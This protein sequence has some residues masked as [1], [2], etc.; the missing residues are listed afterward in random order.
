M[1]AALVLEAGAEDDVLAAQV[2]FHLAAGLDELIVAIPRKSHG[3][4]SVLQPYVELGVAAVVSGDADV[5]RARSRMMKV[6]VE[7]HVNWVAHA[8]AGEFWWPR[9][10]SFARVLALV[11]DRFD[12]VQAAV[13]RVIGPSGDRHFSEHLVSRETGPRSA[14]LTT[15][16]RLPAGRLAIPGYER[17]VGPVLRGWYPFEVLCLTADG[18]TLSH[19]EAGETVQDTRVRDALRTIAGVSVLESETRFAPDRVLGEPRLSF[20]RPDLAADVE[21][22]VELQGAICTDPPVSLEVRAQSLGRRTRALEEGLFGPVRRF[23]P[24]D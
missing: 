11:P 12:A 3:G 19:R 7:R 21:I 4:L 17:E 20:P 2:A 18:G 8:R 15:L 5:S 22:V 14:S 9:Y 1:R 10:G 6:A 13:R 23:R 24:G 16:R